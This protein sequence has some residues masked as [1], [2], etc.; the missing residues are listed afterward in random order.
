MANPQTWTDPST[1][2]TY[3]LIPDTPEVKTW[4]DPT[5]GDT[6]ELVPDAAPA[7]TK[8]AAPK[9][10]KELPISE[11]LAAGYRTAKDEIPYVQSRRREEVYRDLAGKMGKNVV[12]DY[13][14][15]KA[16]I[17]GREMFG[18]DS[19]DYDAVFN[20]AK[21]AGL[22]KDADRASFEKTFLGRDGDR[23]IDMNTVNQN[24]ISG[25]IGGIGSMVADPLN[26]GAGI[27]TGP[28]SVGRSLLGKMGIEGGINAGIEALQLP[29]TNDALENLGQD[30]SAEEMAARVAM[31]GG[32][33]AALGGAGHFLRGQEPQANVDG[34][35]PWTEEE[36]SGITNLIDKGATVDDIAKAFPLTEEQKTAVQFYVDE[37][38]K[39]NDTDVKF[40]DAAAEEPLPFEPPAFL[41][42][43]AKGPFKET[44]DFLGVD[45]PKKGRA[46]PV[47]TAPEAEPVPNPAVN[48]QQ[49]ADHIN[50]VLASDWKNAPRI[51]AVDS[52]DELPPAVR[53]SII[54]DGA[55]DAKGVTVDGEVYI[56]SHNLKDIDD[57]SAVTYHEALG[58]AGLGIQ[59]GKRLNAVLEQ[60][61]NTNEM[62]KSAADAWL[63]KNNTQSTNPVAHAVEEILA[64][65]SEGGKID[66]KIMAKIKTFLKQYARRVPGLKNL[67]YTDKEVF[68]ILSMAQNKVVKGNKT[69]FGVNEARYSTP[70]AANDDRVTLSDR[71]SYP[72]QGATDEEFVKF[73][74]DTAR[75]LNKRADQMEKDG[76]DRSAGNFRA[77]A[78][79]NENLALRKSG[80]AT[81]K[82]SADFF[83]DKAEFYE[84]KANTAFRK[85]QTKTGFMY[86]KSAAE[87]RANAAKE[88]EKALSPNKYS[89]PDEGEQRARGLPVDKILGKK[90]SFYEPFLKQLEADGQPRVVQTWEETKALAEDIGMN[91]DKVMKLDRGPKA[92]EYTAGVNFMM[93]RMNLIGDLSDKVAAGNATDR[94]KD[95]LAIYLR[96]F[97]DMYD[98]LSE[99]RTS[100][101]RT[102][103]IMNRIVENEKAAANNLRYMLSDESESLLNDPS[104][105]QESSH[106]RSLGT[107]GTVRSST[108]Q[109][110]TSWH[111]LCPQ[112]G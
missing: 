16:L 101:A 92:E 82:S 87:N 66:A 84:Q 58:H 99:T 27:A 2:E 70:K 29:L 69:F 71:P 50:N 52:L 65:T 45:I 22:V 61:Y 4:T 44:P 33:G 56:L 1:G 38:A 12:T 6:Y 111:R 73:Y 90:K 34:V 100:I 97:A 80:K 19:Y 62:V 67:K 41:E 83:R 31:A 32:F 79:E 17:P 112:V 28:A 64:E 88:A 102:L 23:N 98:V 93:G 89:K 8:T 26:V 54:D 35:R 74:Q 25:F 42:R 57:L 47:K 11:G 76:R 81:P 63:A 75:Y 51:T 21:K 59:F 95:K 39:G 14:S 48:K 24:P 55:E 85:G 94:D 108:V 96:Q 103:N 15:P 20:D 53:Q 13:F 86:Q 37:K 9:A 40:E 3:E 104:K 68:A 78:K 46:A 109:Y 10:P 91:V 77:E 7:P 60:M 5:T 30:M 105:L 36:M 43:P 18:I 107:A 110:H 106:L 72:R 49:A